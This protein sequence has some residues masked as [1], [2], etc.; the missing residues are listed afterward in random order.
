MSSTV[1]LFSI[2]LPTFSDRPGV[3]GS[4]GSHSSSATSM[5]RVQPNRL[6]LCFLVVHKQAEVPS[7]VT[8]HGF[9]FQGPFGGEGTEQSPGPSSQAGDGLLASF[10]KRICWTHMHATKVMVCSVGWVLGG[11]C[12]FSSPDIKR[13]GWEGLDWVF[14]KVLSVAEMKSRSSETL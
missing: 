1:P 12:G 14:L 11:S 5:W 3:P 4:L 8:V 2:T 7:P 10:C 6:T 9:L 13:G